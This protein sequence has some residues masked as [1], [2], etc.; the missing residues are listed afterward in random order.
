MWSVRR[1][2]VVFLAVAVS[3][4]L[5]GPGHAAVGSSAASFLN[6]PVGGRPAALGGAYGALASDAY[7]PVWNPA[8]LGA[9]RRSEAALT[10]LDYAD[11]IGYEYAGLAVPVGA[12]GIGASMQYLHPKAITARDASGLETGTFAAHYAAY[13]LAYGRA[14]APALTLGGAVKLIDARIDD[15][16]A[17]TA[18]ADLGGLYRVD[19][20][21]AISA[22]AG[23]LG[24][25]LKFLND[26]DRLPAN[27]RVGTLFSATRA[28]DFVAEGEFSRE[29]SAAARVGAEWR[30]V[31]LLALRAGYHGDA[32]SNVPGLSGFTTGVGLEAYG[33]R[34]DYAWVPMGDLGQTQYFSVVLSFGK[35]GA[36]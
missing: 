28:W 19:H 24:A 20:R 22:V 31:P 17:R 1:G 4:A 29:E 11:A 8:G 36:R 12:G 23:N 26:A 35:R 3:V 27:L 15:L 32:R 33:Q 9:L 30:P 18:A 34:F 14:V 13:S 21:W 25:K 10:H 2:S 7:A 6:I 16:S 5:A